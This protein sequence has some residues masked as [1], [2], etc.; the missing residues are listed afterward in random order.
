MAR[1]V[2]SLGVAQRTARK[3]EPQAYNHWEPNSAKKKKK[4]LDW[5]QVHS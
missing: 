3:W 4:K 5:K 2:S 1:N